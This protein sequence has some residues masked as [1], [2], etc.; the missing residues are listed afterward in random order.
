MRIERDPSASLSALFRPLPAPTDALQQDVYREQQITVV[1]HLLSMGLINIFNGLLVAV[2]A[3][4]KVPLINVAIWYFPILLMGLFQL[5]SSWRLRNVA[6]PKKV[7][8]SYLR[9]A[10]F[11]TII[12]GMVWGS[13]S[14][15]LGGNGD[16]AHLF[17]VWMMQAG[18]AAGL[19]SLLGP[20]PRMTMRF[21]MACLLPVTVINFA[22]GG[23]YALTIALLSLVFLASLVHGSMNSYRHLKSMIKTVRENRRSRENLA[24]A[25]ESSNDAFAFYDS[26]DQLLIANARHRHWFGADKPTFHIGEESVPVLLK[27]GRWL[28]RSTRE[29]GTGGAVVVHTDITALKTRERELIEAQREAVEADAAKSRFLSTM[30][31][32]LRTPMNIIL[33]FSKLMNGDSKIRLSEDEIREYADNIHASG[34]HLLKLINDIIDYSKVGLD[35]IAINP[36]VVDTKSLLTEAITLAAGFESKTTIDSFDVAVSSKLSM[37]MV[38]ETAMKRILINLITNAIRFNREGCKVVI[39]AGLDGEGEPFIAVRDFG[40]GIPENKLERVFE[41]FYQGDSSLDRHYGGTGLGL[42]L[43]RHLSRLLSGDVELKS[44][45]G[46]GTTAI[47]KLPKSALIHDEQVTKSD[48]DDKQRNVA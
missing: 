39:R 37:M 43:C 17:F 10:E 16:D 21:A 44:R 13:A 9:K 42:T 27:N 6:P 35:R 15:L 14:L 7:S 26:D 1:K 20:V 33:G 3:A 28:M 34:T 22:R 29:T 40:P 36:T 2:A 5:F 11:A 24:D 31:H 23:D 30:S 32:E 18:M 4:A 41:A 25:I 47:L 45:V 8:G 48:R 19:T 38:D 12:I 46:V